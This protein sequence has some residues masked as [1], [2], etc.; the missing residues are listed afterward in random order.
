MIVKR[1]GVQRPSTALSLSHRVAWSMGVRVC[2]VPSDRLGPALGHGPATGEV[3][4]NTVLTST[5]G[6]AGMQSDFH[7]GL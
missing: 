1:G 6:R 5:V 4:Y 2:K 3:A 7:Q